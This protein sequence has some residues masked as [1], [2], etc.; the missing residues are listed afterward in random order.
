MILFLK[1]LQKLE[2]VLE[3]VFESTPSIEDWNLNIYRGISEN[4]SENIAKHWKTNEV[5]A[6]GN[7]ERMDKVVCKWGLTF[8]INSFNST[9][10]MLKLATDSNFL[11]KLVSKLQ[12]IDKKKN[13]K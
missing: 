5:E 9:V 3:V 12:Q 2:A 13:E 11:S 1:T 7:K 6:V 8:Y 10:L 4:I